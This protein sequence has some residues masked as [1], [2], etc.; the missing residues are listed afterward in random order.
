MAKTIVWIE[1]DTD[2][3][4]PVVR[5]L[6]LEG[7]QFVRLRN[8]KEALEAVDQIREAD[9]ILLD[10]ILPP[11]EMD[12]ELKRYSRYPGL[13]ALHE[14]REV[15]NVDVPVMV[16]TVVSRGEIHRRLRELGVADI[17]TKPVRPSELKERVERVLEG[18]S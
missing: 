2:I 5:P 11:G 13:E 9:L 8:V 1:D 16:L 14:L 7:H 17:V 18:E 6:E 3:I 15:H 12:W 10:M 4:D